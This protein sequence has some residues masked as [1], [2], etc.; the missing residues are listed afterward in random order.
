MVLL[1]CAKQAQMTSLGVFQGVS[2]KDKGKLTWS[3]LF[4]EMGLWR[5]CPIHDSILAT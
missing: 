3:W 2:V 5:A 4:A 1:S